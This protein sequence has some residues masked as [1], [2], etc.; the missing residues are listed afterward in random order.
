M[1]M[2]PIT[3]IIRMKL[4]MI[5]STTISVVSTLNEASVLR[6]CV[7]KNFVAGSPKTNLISYKLSST[8]VTP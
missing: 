4:K 8:L 5:R 1:N 6:I 7:R 3:I 2:K